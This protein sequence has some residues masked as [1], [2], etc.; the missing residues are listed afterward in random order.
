MTVSI[1]G[2]LSVIGIKNYQAQ[3]N[4]AKTAEA[5]YSLSAVYSAEENFREV[6]GTYH[7]NLIIIGVIPDG[8]YHYDVGFGKSSTLSKTDGLLGSYPVSADLQ[9]R[10][11]TN[12]RQICD[13]SND[14]CLGKATQ[15]SGAKYTYF[16]YGDPN[17]LVKGKALIFNCKVIGRLYIKDYASIGDKADENT[18]TA[19]ATGKLKD[20]DVWSVDEDKTF[21][22]VEDG[23]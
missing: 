16:F 17:A 3:T 9:V 22:H 20:D 19:I 13:T 11:C 12:F 7:E 15:V 21:D 2:V 5:K 10:E 8:V 4:K 23:T 18:F 14:D 6:W 1:A